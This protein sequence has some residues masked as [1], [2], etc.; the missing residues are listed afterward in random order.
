[1]SESKR[2]WKW[3]NIENRKSSVS[4]FQQLPSFLMYLIGTVPY[5][6]L[7]PPRK[8]IVQTDRQTDRQTE[9][10]KFVR[11]FDVPSSGVV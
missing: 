9:K 5:L 8:G 4:S 1:M 6:I 10:S 11:N 3:K 2:E 7:T